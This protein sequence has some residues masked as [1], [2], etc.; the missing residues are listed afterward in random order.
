MKGFPFLLGLGLLA[1]CGKVE[2]SSTLESS[3][4]ALRPSGQ[5]RTLNSLERSRMSSICQAIARKSSLLE[6][7]LPSDVF[8]F[9]VSNTDCDGKVSLTSTVGTRIR[10][11]NSQYYFRPV[12]E[13]ESVPFA[14][15]ETTSTG[16]LAAVCRDLANVTEV[17]LDKGNGE[18][19]YLSTLETGDCPLRTNELCVLM[20]TASKTSNGDFY[21]VHTTEWLRVYTNQD[22]SSA[23][24]RFYGFITDRRSATSG[25]CPERKSQTKRQTL[26]L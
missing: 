2:F 25:F 22:L 23:N 17:P 7:Q 13:G 8:S 5:S 1:G 18:V 26:K 6:A 20:E 16:R 19:L 15:V 4:G 12:T 3:I 14:E 9:E 10:N 11:D 24:A 21:Q